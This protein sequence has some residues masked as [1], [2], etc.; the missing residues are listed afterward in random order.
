MLDRIEVPDSLNEVL[1]EAFNDDD[2]AR[3][4]AFLTE[5]VMGL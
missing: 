1:R 4:S 3:R 5:N 2:M